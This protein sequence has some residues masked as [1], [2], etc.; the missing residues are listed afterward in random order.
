MKFT[1]RFLLYLDAN[2]LYDDGMSQPLPTGDFRWE[3]P[4]TYKWK[5]PPE[6]RG[7]I[8]ECDLE[9]TVNA[10]LKTY[11]FPLAPEKLKVNKQEL[12]E[13]QLNCLETEDKKIGNVPKLILNLKDKKD[14]VIHYELLKY[15]ETLGLK[16]KKVSRIISFKQA[17][18]LQ[19]YIDLNTKERTKANSDFEKD[20]WKLMNNAFY[21]KTMENIR[22]RINLKFAK[23]K[24]QARQMFSKPTYKDHIIFTDDLIAILNNNPSVKFNKPIYLGMCILDFS[25]LTMYKFYYE[26]INKL[27]LDNEIIGY[28]TD[29]FFLNITTEDV[30]KDMLQILD[31]LDTSNYPKNY[32]LYSDKNKKVIGKFKDE[33]AGMI[34]SEIVF[35]RSKAYSFLVEK[36]CSYEGI[37]LNKDQ[38]KLLKPAKKLKGITKATITRN[39]VFQEYKDAIL[40]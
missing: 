2:N 6:G 16:V 33:L 27:W 15:Y 24:E 28:D 14:Y 7:C 4:E 38:E 12:S 21:G 3:D 26:K 9:Y 29:S 20:L 10:K 1:T 30:Y 25:K 40:I 18:W 32:F 23:T 31:D 39:I 13:Y 34:M 8:V 37:K 35:L 11:K 19:K 5:T 36:G 17:P 22:E